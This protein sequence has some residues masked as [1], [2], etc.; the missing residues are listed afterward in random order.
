MQMLNHG[1]STGALFLLVGMIYDR[2]HTRM[3][4]S[5]GGL[6]HHSPVL[7][8]F[9]LVVTL[10]SIGLP[11]LN[12]FVGEVLVLV[13]TFLKNRAYAAVAA[14]GMIL[15][16]VYM[17]WMYQRV[18]LGKVTDPANASMGDIG[19]R[20]RTVLIPI[21]IM[22]LWMGVYPAPFL[23]RMDASLE[24]VRKRVHDS[25]APEGG[26]RVRQFNAPALGEGDG[27]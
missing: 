12:G 21:V 4:A 2:R 1:L 19:T 26:Y 9:F 23:R 10:S 17:L 6:A 3:I 16:A 18:F 24:M 14:S 8:A 13:G 25:R 7:A 27:R 22:M 5:F 20:D 11:G 15:G